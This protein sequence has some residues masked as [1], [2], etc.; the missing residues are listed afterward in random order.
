MTD[1][2]MVPERE[3][4]E[5]E[6]AAYVECGERMDQYWR[7]YRCSPTWDLEQTAI[8]RYPLP[9]V[10]RRRKERD[11]HGWVSQFSVAVYW[12]LESKSF[13]VIS[14]DINGA[15]LAL[16]AIPITPKRIALWKDLIDRPDEEVEG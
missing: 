12:T 11:P 5:R 15:A 1:E 10:T 6:R 2:K 8:A 7:W 13:E 9:R 3:A 14:C 4:V 16:N